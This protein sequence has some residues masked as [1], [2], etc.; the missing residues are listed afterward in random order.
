MIEFLW[1]LALIALPL[2]LLVFWL[3]PRVNHEE[4]ALQVPF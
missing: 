2:P 4:A 3:L 1:P